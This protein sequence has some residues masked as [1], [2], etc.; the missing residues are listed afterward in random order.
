MRLLVT[1][2]FALFLSAC[3]TPG[4][5][6]LGDSAQ[7]SSKS[8]NN[9]TFNPELPDGYDPSKQTWFCMR[10]PLLVN[11]IYKHKIKS[12]D[13]MLVE[14]GSESF[15]NLGGNI[16]KTSYSLEGLERRWDWGYTE[17]GSS[18]AISFDGRVANFY[19]FTKDFSSF[20]QRQREG[21]GTKSS[22]SYWCLDPKYQ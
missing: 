19:D 20:T 15:L 13:L 4:D 8:W 18:Y 11:D 2:L 22:F 3:E 16:I 6:F 21:Y 14:D 9:R 1:S 17:K 12:V 10:D 7:S 5:V